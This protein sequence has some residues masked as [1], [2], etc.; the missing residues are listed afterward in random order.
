V[1]GGRLR[2]P[3]A[4]TGK[5]CLDEHAA[6]FV[7]DGLDGVGQDIHERVRKL[8]RV[9]DHVHVVRQRFHADPATLGAGQ[10]RRFRHKLPQELID[11]HRR[12]APARGGGKGKQLLVQSGAPIGQMGDAV[13]VRT[14]NGG[15]GIRIAADEFGIPLDTGQNVVEVMDDPGRQRGQGLP[16]F[17]FE[18]PPDL[19]RLP[20]SGRQTEVEPR[21]RP[22][23]KVGLERARLAMKQKIAPGRPVRMRP[24]AEFFKDPLRRRRLQFSEHIRQRLAA[25]HAVEKCAVGLDG[26]PV[27][28]KDRHGFAHQFHQIRLQTPG[29]VWSLPITGASR[30]AAP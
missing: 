9:T 30:H 18:I 15:F 10:R 20:G 5:R 7:L 8:K 2:G 29:R 26:A 23:Q 19:V 24:V 27:R 6:R 16:F 25:G 13:G 11:G 3:T 1:R 12:V 4:A 14:N 21:G 17:T 22:R 28:L